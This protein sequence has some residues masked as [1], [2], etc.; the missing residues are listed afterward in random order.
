MTSLTIHNL[1]DD[2]EKCLRL[3]AA[4]HGRSM[5]E[6]ARAI[7]LTALTEPVA[8]VN[9]ARSIHARFAPLGGVVLDIMPREPMHNPPRFEKR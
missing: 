6:E 3:R 7:L 1:G 5:E 4:Q 2:L 8:P 9:L